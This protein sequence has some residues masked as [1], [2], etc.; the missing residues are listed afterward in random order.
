MATDF[1][2][3]RT[4]QNL[5]ENLRRLRAAQGLTQAALAERAGVPRSTLANLEADGG[6]PTLAVLG[7]L[8]AALRVTLEELLSTPHA[9]CRVFRE[10]TLPV[11]L[12]GPGR[13]ARVHRLL[14]DPVPG[15]EIDRFELARAARMRGVPHRAG[16]REY[17]YCERGQLTLWAAGERYDLAAGDLAT[18]H[19]DQPHSYAN[20][21][22]GTAVGFSVVA[23]VRNPDER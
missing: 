12:R 19:G 18:F 10:G 21:G 7:G 6:N 13:A 15:M 16:T 17:L 2:L 8:A 1:D 23:F 14:P 9:A 3:S 5:S 4:Q 11:E 20:E 22:E